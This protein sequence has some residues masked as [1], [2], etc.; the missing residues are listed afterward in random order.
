MEVPSGLYDDVVAT[1]IHVIKQD[2][3]ECA[4]AIEEI[5]AICGTRAALRAALVITLLKMEV[6]KNQSV[7][8]VKLQ[9]YLIRDYPQAVPLLERA[10]TCWVRAWAI[11][12]GEALGLAN[13]YP[14][15]AA[16]RASAAIPLLPFI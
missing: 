14:T 1:D 5:L 10:I 9:T 2:S 13:E 16:R 12:Q 15:S 6:Q 7:E 11:R 3:P 4:A 8:N